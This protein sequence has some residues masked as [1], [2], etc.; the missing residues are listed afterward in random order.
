MNDSAV[1]ETPAGAAE[2]AVPRL[3]VRRRPPTAEILT[4]YLLLTPQ[5]LGFALFVLVP[6]VGVVALSFTA[7]D[8]LSGQTRPV[9]LANYT[10]LFTA[11]PTFWQSLITSAVFA[12]GLIVINVALSLALALALDRRPRGAEVFLT[13][14]FLSV[15]TSQAAWAIVWRFLLQGNGGTINQLLGL[16]GLTG[17]NWLYQPGPALAAVTVVA[18]LKTVGLKAVIFLAAI[19]SIPA[20]RLEAARLDGANEWRVTRHIVL[21]LI[22]PTTLVVVLITLVGSFQ[23]FD[24]IQLMTHGGPSHA[25]S[26]LAYYIYEQAFELFQ[27]GYASALAVVLFVLTLILVLCQ[28]MARKKWVYGE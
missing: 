6:L 15:V 25:T 28:W 22:A 13:L 21:P 5:T 2:A 9:G 14:A 4:A 24:Y 19:R 26:V 17:P 16:L 18:A 10:H 11:D 3:R 8:L 7:T 1:L 20:D 27:T 12:G 23:V